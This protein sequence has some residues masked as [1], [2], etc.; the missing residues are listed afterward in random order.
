[1]IK[2]EMFERG[3]LTMPEAFARLSRTPAGLFGLEAGTLE[4]GAPADVVVVDPRKPWHVE[5]GEFESMGRNT[6]FAGETLLG[7]VEAV[8][9]GGNVAVRDG[10]IVAERPAW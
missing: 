5:P 1:M 7:K 9:I 4:I 6:P 8:I 10:R 2:D 3:P